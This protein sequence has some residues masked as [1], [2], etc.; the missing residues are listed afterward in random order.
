MIFT[1]FIYVDGDDAFGTKKP[2]EGTGSKLA[3]LTP[4]GSSSSK[5]K[6][7]P[8][9]IISQG[10]THELSPDIEQLIPEDSPFSLAID[11]SRLDTEMLRRAFSNAPTIEI[12]TQTKPL[13]PGSAWAVSQTGNTGMISLAADPTESV[14]TLK[15][16][17]VGVLN[18]RDEEADK[19][20][21]KSSSK[22]W[23]QWG[24]IL[25]SAQLLFFKDTIWTGA[26]QSQIA[27]QAGDAQYRE[28]PVNIVVTPRISYFRPDGV[29]SLSDAIAVCDETSSLTPNTFRLFAEQAGTSRQY[30]I[31]ASSPDEMIDWMA[32]INFCAAFRS[33][34][35]RRLD[36]FTAEERA[37]LQRVRSEISNSSLGTTLQPDAS[38]AT[39]STVHLVPERIDAMV[40]QSNAQVQQRLTERVEEIAPKLTHVETSL[41]ALYQELEDNLR[42]ARHFAI[43]TPFQKS[44]REHIETAAVPLSHKIRRLRLDAIKAEARRAILA[45]EHD[46]FRKL[47]GSST[48]IL[49]Y[50]VENAQH[51]I[52]EDSAT[53]SAPSMNHPYGKGNPSLRVDTSAA[54]DYEQGR[55]IE[56]EFTPTLR[57]SQESDGDLRTPARPDLISGPS[58]GAL[59]QTPLWS[60]KSPSGSTAVST[61]AGESALPPLPGETSSTPTTSMS[62]RSASTGLSP[63]TT[64]NS[65]TV[66]ADESAED[67]HATAAAQEKRI[68]L[69]TLPK[70]SADDVETLTR[71]HKMGRQKPQPK[72]ALD[73]D[74]FTPPTVSYNDPGPFA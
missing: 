58:E 28:D 63:M 30:L 6:I 65:S 74:M 52:T 47:S 34:G 11:Y 53:R 61:P 43:M 62:T 18:R 7:D 21:K 32:K 71:A 42:L 35:V 24:F 39:S 22:K 48:P 20:S 49:Q 29:L 15:V 2:G 17:K 45:R 4:G 72:P 51:H 10:R 31:Q 69:A 56:D 50:A 12:V 19:S 54:A 36:A 44:T 13:Q 38:S 8:Y 59:P 70:L 46:Q 27:D 41:D 14:V 25:T 3:A 67:W 16:T 57:S 73:K 5:N 55:R 23:K 40:K 66:S 26:L 60:V 33:V 64:P 37:S 68:S 9:W 1:Q